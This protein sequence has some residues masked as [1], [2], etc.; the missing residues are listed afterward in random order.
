VR[1]TWV[2]GSVKGID[3]VEPNGTVHALSIPADTTPCLGFFVVTF[4]QTTYV[5]VEV[6]VHTQIEDWEEIDAVEL[7]GVPVPSAT[8]TPTRTPTT[9]GPTSTPTTGAT[10][11]TPTRTPTTGGPTATPT[12]GAATATPTRT[13]TTGGPTATPTRTPSPG[14]P[15]ATPT[16]TATPGGPTATPTVTGPTGFKVF[17]PLNLRQH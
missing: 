5:V 2:P 8:A 12:T 15:T 3:L 1:E 10:T 6:I 13:P 17:L 16:R 4:P 14:G 7:V 9:G 11:A